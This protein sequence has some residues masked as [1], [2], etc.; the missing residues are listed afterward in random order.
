MTEPTL[1]LEDTSDEESQGLEPVVPAEAP[2]IKPAKAKKSAKASEDKPVEIISSE[3]NKRVRIILEENDNIPPTGLFI[4]VNGR[5]FLIR[6]GEEVSVPADVV[7]ALN[8]AV[9]DIPKLDS[10]NNVVDYRKK[11]RFPYRILG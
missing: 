11:M 10:M 1:P 6:P 8:D 9:E 7:E 5:S 3:Q 2:A 4:G